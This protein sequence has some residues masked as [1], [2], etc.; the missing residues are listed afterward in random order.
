MIQ[1]SQEQREAL[2]KGHDRI[3]FEDPVTKKVYVLAERSALQ[4]ADADLL[5]IQRGLRELETEGGVE[6][7]EFRRELYTELRKEFRLPLPEVE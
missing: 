4:Q 1:L 2:S 6:F 7:E 5:A 3:E